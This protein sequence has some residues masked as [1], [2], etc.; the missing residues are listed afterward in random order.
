VGKTTV[1]DELIRLN[2]LSFV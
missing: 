1:G 2:K